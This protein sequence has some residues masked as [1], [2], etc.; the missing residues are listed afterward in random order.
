MYSLGTLA[1]ENAKTSRFQ[2]KENVMIR[3]ERNIVGTTQDSNYEHFNLRFGS[4]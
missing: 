2:E 1:F 3:R 4:H